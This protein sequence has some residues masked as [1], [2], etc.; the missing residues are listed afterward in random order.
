MEKRYLRSF[1]PV[2]GLCL[3]LIAALLPAAGTSAR[4]SAAPRL[5]L[6]ATSDQVTAYKYKRQAAKL[7]AG[8]FLESTRAALEFRLERP[9]YDK[10]VRVF[11]I[12]NGNDRRLPDDLLEGFHLYDGFEHFFQVVARDQNGDI[13][14]DGTQKFCPSAEVREQVIPGGPDEEVFILGCQANEFT[15]GMR[16]GIEKGWAADAFG[17]EKARI[18]VPVGDYDVTISIT[19]RYRDLLDIP[20]SDAKVTLDVNVV[21]TSQC[22]SCDE[23]FPEP[24]ND[25]I[26]GPP[27]P[28]M[29]P[30]GSLLPDLRPLPPYGINVENDGEGNS[31][32]GFA[33][34]IWASG[35]DLVV[36]G[37]KNGEEMDAFQYFFQDGTAIGRADVGNFTYDPRDGH[38]HWHLDDFSIYRLIDVGSGAVI[39]SEKQ[40][41]CLG[42]TSPTDLTVP[43][44]VLQDV[45]PQYETDCGQPDSTWIREVIPLGW[46]DTYHQALPGQSFDITSV[47]NGKYLIQIEANPGGFLYEKRLGNNVIERKVVL[48]GRAGNRKVDFGPVIGA[49]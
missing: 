41:F 24:G 30:D 16:W 19:K 34:H 6:F 7:D 8:I 9:R 5:R 13:V 4:P 48:R 44:A 1:G 23:A 3:I 20:K 22:F 15:K 12:L 29:T 11:Q 21:K 35:S 26:Q 36:E 28:D 42:A 40:G 46:G 47:P 2:L 25:P 45:K 17:D 37:Y 31:Y 33:S 32:L 43:G 10:P 27:V 38:F 18:K 14:S 49:S 39:T